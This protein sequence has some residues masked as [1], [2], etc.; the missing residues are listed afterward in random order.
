MRAIKGLLYLIMQVMR[1]RGGLIIRELQW[2]ELFCSHYQWFNLPCVTVEKIGSFRL[3][4]S[5][6]SNIIGVLL[7][8][9]IL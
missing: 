9:F 7:D 2:L 6:W 8:L 1:T 4:S 3:R 5:V